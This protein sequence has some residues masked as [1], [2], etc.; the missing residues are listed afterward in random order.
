LVLCT[1]LPGDVNT[2]IAKSRLELTEN[3]LGEYKESYAKMKSILEKEMKSA[4]SPD[5]VAKTVLKLLQKKNMPLKRVSGSTLHKLTPIIKNVLPQK[6][7]QR[8]IIKHY[9]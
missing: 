4:I 2:Q 6:W 3:E 5:A 1:V 7:F 8:L 9:S